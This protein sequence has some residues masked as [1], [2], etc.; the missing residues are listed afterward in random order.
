MNVYFATHATT[1]DN[2]AGIA[3]GRKDVALSPTGE[4]Q[5]RALP[6]LLRGIT[7]TSLSPPA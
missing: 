4:A 7:S 3:S 2:E 6:G 5:A 1:F